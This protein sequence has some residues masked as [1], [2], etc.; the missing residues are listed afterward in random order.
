MRE[1]RLLSFNFWIFLTDFTHAFS[2]HVK[3]IFYFSKCYYLGDLINWTML[4]VSASVRGWDG[5]GIY[6][7]HPRSA[8]FPV[9]NRVRTAYASVESQFLTGL[10]KTRVF[11]FFLEKTQP[12][13]VFWVLGF[14]LGGLFVFFGIFF[15]WFFIL[16]NI[17]ILSI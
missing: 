3:L 2:Q 8:C 14:F 16:N 5:W 6:F 9:R 11:C 13:S 1:A 4:K 17:S 12:T 15:L 10:A 7:I